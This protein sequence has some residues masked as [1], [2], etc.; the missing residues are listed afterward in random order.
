[1]GINKINARNIKESR[2]FESLLEHLN[3]EKIGR[4]TRDLNWRR[5]AKPAKL[6]YMTGFQDQIY[7]NLNLFVNKLILSRRN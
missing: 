5:K 6:H 3:F 4:S 1:M 2:R 7:I